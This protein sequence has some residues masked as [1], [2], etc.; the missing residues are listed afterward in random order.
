MNKE[1]FGDIENEKRE[2][3]YS[4]YLNSISNKDLIK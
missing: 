3:H 1:M 4:K 2:F